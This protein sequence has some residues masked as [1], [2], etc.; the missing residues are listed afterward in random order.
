MTDFVIFSGLPGTGK[1]TLANRLARELRWPLL[2]I[3]DVIGEVPENA[4]V[5]FW[6]SRVA[7]LLDLIETQLELGLDV[8]ADSVFMNMD[9][10]HAQELARKY[11]TR[12]L[13]I[14]VYI[15]DENLW[16]ERVIT[17]FNELNKRDVA[18]WERIQHQ[19]EHFRTWE[20]GTALFIDSLHSLEENY[21]KVLDFVSGED[22]ALRPLEAIPLSE[23]RYHQERVNP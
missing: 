1:S 13:P 12:F 2:C 18:T 8:I 3:D 22:M 21:A 20:P 14:H 11:Q 10:H 19:R 5:E 6:D 16:K 4:G 15:S 23:G 9:R 17:R 7:I